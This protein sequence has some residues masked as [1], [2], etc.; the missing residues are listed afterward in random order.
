MVY[1]TK[2]TAVFATSP[3]ILCKIRVQHNAK[4]THN[5]LAVD[6]IINGTAITNCI[7]P[8]NWIKQS[9][10]MAKPFLLFI[11]S[12]FR[13]FF[14]VFRHSRQPFKI[15]IQFSFANFSTLTN[16]QEKK[17][18]WNL[19]MMTNQQ[20][21]VVA[22]GLRKKL[23]FAGILSNWDSSKING[24]NILRFFGRV[25]GPLTFH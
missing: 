18:S 1:F 19:L 23:S 2:S 11:L 8:H 9:T 13:P 20:M 21:N 10:T 4:P 3:F 14:C 6:I 24:R 12:F 15:I 17:R 22:G 7:F 5:V 25:R 16:E